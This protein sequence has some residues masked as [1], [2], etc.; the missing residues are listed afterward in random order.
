MLIY[1]VEDDPLKADTLLSFLKTTDPSS[2]IKVFRSYNTGLTAI[3]ALRPHL[4][5][6][7][8]TLPTY[9]RTPARRAGRLRP[10]GGYELLRKIALHQIIVPAIV[11]TMLESFGEGVEEISYQ[12]MTTTCKSELGELFLGSIYFQLGTS[13]WQIELRNIYNNFKDEGT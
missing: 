4:L 3:Q 11:V 9:D 1:I 10:L 8:M 6:L 12:D 5:I 13:N 7:D 2:E